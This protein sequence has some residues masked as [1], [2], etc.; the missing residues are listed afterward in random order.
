M[1]KFF[2]HWSEC[3]ETW[4]RSRWPN[5]SPRELACKGTGKLGLD[6]KSLDKLQALRNELGRPVILTS[7]Y[8]SPEHN[9]AVGGAKY[10]QHMEAKAFDVMQTNQEPANFE[11]AARKVG[12][13]G[14]GFYQRSNFIHIDTGPAREWGA[15]W[16]VKTAD[17][18]PGE[19]PIAPQS[20]M[21]DTSF[22]GGIMTAGAGLGGS[23]FSAM[24]GLH[25][26]VQGVLALAV[27]GLA[28]AA[29]YEFFIK[30]K[31][32]GA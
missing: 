28:V 15:R 30:P 27:V 16:T 19:Q 29:I 18:L 12:F 23:L 14:F 17:A 5:F 1:D 9:R 31:G 6:F 11:R 3:D 13:T 21:Q 7:A 2:N 20:L 22:R 32:E 26:V 25:P 24:P 10:S 4:F 8:R